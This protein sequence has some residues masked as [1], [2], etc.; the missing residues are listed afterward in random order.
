MRVNW[1]GAQV[2]MLRRLD[3]MGQRGMAP[4]L[5]VGLRGERE[6]LFELRRRGYVVVARRWRTPKLPGDV[7]LVAWDGEWLCLVE[8]KTRMGRDVAAP[9]E[10][11]VDDAKRDMLRQMARAYVRRFPERLRREV[12]VRFDVVSVYLLADDVEFEV[13]KGAFGWVSPTRQAVR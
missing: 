4:H 5:K 9:A 13:Y 7:D 10:S 1:L 3:A 12:P 8:V 11:Q 6:A 2:W